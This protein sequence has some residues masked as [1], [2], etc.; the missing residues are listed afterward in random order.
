MVVRIQELWGPK[1]TKHI[2]FNGRHGITEKKF[3]D[4]TFNKKDI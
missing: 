4:I 3:F 1:D 2:Q